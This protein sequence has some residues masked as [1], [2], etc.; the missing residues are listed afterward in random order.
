VSGR[1][2]AR[3]VVTARGGAGSPQ[4]AGRPLWGQRTK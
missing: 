1:P 3:I 2:P 4:A